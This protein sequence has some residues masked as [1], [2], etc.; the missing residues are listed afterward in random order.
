MGSMNTAGFNCRG[1]EQRG[2]GEGV[3]TALGVEIH[4]DQ[5]GTGARSPARD[6]T[7]VAGEGSTGELETS[8][9]I[10][11]WPTVYTPPMG[12][13]LVDIDE[14][15]LAAAQAELGTASMKDTVNEALRRATVR[16]SARGGR[17]S[18]AL[19]NVVFRPVRKR[20]ANPSPGYERGQP[21]GVAE[22]R[23]VVDPLAHTGRLGCLASPTSRWVTEVVMPA[24]G[25][26]TWLTSLSSS[27]WKP[28]LITC[29][30]PGRFSASSL[31]AASEDGRSLICLLPWLARRRDSRCFTTTMTS[32]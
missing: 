23:A 30:E 15:A 13:H 28:R 14:A 2:V 22:V 8:A 20:G 6:V 5:P 25:T 10:Y 32:S 29:G 1:Q 31:H 18:T 9:S 4:I 26:R 27:L 7:A 19:A 12:K 24:S 16:R 3:T 11:T 17:H 21:P